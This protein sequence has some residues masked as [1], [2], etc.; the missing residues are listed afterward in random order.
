MMSGRTE[1]LKQIYLGQYK[2]Q[3]QEGMRSAWKFKTLFSASKISSMFSN[4]ETW[5]GVNGLLH[6][7]ATIDTVL[8]YDSLATRRY[9]QRNIIEDYWGH[10]ILSVGDLK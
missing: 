4:V 5:I 10:D 8:V 2:I 9:V 7:Q 3:T 6:K 1:E